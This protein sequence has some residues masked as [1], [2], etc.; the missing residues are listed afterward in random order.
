[1]KRIP[2][3]LILVLIA[4][5]LIGT[6]YAR[7]AKPEDAIKYRQSVM[8]LM[9]HHLNPMWAFFQGKAAHD[10]DAISADADVIAKLA[11]LPWEAF[12][13][14]G[15][16]KGDTRMTSAVF[17]KKAQFK[18]AATSFEM[19]SA[20]LAATARGGDL[21]AIKAQIGNVGENCYSCHKKFRK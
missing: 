10:K 13:E 9:Q 1:M 5:L 2:G 8:V 20:E 3:I 6:A 21:K 14:P 11:P 15:T 12:M 17:K 4:L 19:L 18:E 7:F 16:D